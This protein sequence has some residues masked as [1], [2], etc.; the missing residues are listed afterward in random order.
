MPYLNFH[1]LNYFRVVAHT[2]NLTKAAEQL[3]VSQSALSTQIRQLEDQLGQALFE[4]QHRRLILTEAGRVALDYADSIHESGTELLATLRDGVGLSRQIVRIGAVATLSRNFQESF[5]APL[6]G[7]EDVALAL[8]SG[9]LGDLLARLAAHNLDMVL[10]NKRVL[11]DQAQPWHCRRIAHQ[12]VSLVGAPRRRRKRKQFVFPDD[13]RDMDL[14]V[15]SRESDLRLGFDALC[16]Q[17]HL[18]PRLMA[19]VDDMAMIRLLARSTGAPAVVPSVVV[20]DELKQGVLQEY[21]QL[22]NLFEDFYAIIVKRRYQHP[23]IAS[24]LKRQEDE[25]LP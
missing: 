4:R 10:S 19:E 12:P 17:H 22:P 3:H 1:H 2:G 16:E 5:L 25:I 6:V 18:R 13:M 7:R 23:L 24:L 8:S 9:S 21:C 14:I 11:P 20:R 15:P